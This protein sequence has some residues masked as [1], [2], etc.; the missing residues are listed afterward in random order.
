MKFPILLVILII[1]KFD[2][3]LAAGVF[4]SVIRSAGSIFISRIVIFQE[5]DRRVVYLDIFGSCKSNMTADIT[6]V[7]LSEDGNR[8]TFV[9]ATI[10][11]YRDINPNLQV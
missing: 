2:Q 4:V 3:F 11:I 8:K 1:L 6:N 5:K 10:Q 7:V 9:N